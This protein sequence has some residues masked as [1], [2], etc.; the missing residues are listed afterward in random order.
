MLAEA[1]VKMW[2]SVYDTFGEVTE[3]DVMHSIRAHRVKECPEY[4]Q[5]EAAFRA[6][7]QDLLRARREK[8]VEL[9]ELALAQKQASDD[10]VM[11]E[12]EARMQIAAEKVH[13]I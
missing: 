11:E 7:L 13:E 6:K 10:R 2:D 4:R 12:V 1:N 9:R 3:Q 5:M 8:L